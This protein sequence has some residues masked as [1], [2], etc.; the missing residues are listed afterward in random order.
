MARPYSGDEIIRKGGGCRRRVLPGTTDYYIHDE[1]GRPTFRIDVPSHDSLSQW[2]MPI[3]TPAR[4]ARADERILLA[5]DRAGSSADHMVALHLLIDSPG[6]ERRD[7][8]D[9]EVLRPRLERGVDR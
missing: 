9:D 7:L 3:G 1:D 4:C 6:V 2:L 8:L 5:L